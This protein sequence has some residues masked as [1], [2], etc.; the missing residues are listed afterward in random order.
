MG[1]VKRF[2][3]FRFAMADPCRFFY[4]SIDSIRV[5]LLPSLLISLPYLDRNKQYDA[6]W[7]GSADPSLHFDLTIRLPFSHLFTHGPRLV[8]S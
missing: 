1:T 4:D 8:C 7:V 5:H 6:C 3:F 2:Q